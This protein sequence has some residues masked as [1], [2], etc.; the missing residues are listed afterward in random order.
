MKT[1]FK[2]VNQV[3][4]GR[5]VKYPPKS[6]KLKRSEMKQAVWEVVHGKDAH[7]TTERSRRATTI[8][9]GRDA[10]TGRFVSRKNAKSQT[11]EVVVETIK[12][13]KRTK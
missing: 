12:R 4:R 8:K 2:E 11:D 10:K 5:T 7:R 3:A 6:G 1:R 13:P 9:V